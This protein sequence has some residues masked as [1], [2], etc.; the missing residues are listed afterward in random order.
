MGQALI[1]HG[2]EKLTEKGV[3]I[4]VTY[5]APAFYAKVGFLPLS[6]ETIPPPFDLSQPDG[7]LGPPLPRSPSPPP[8]PLLVRGG[9]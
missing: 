5:G 1:T 7:W 4:V 6:P 3:D 2:L 9:V 8:R